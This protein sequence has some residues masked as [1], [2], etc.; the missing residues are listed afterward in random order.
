MTGAGRAVGVPRT[1]EEITAGWLAEV[2]GTDVGTITVEPVGL[3]IGLMG[4]LYR[5]RSD[6]DGVPPV[7]V[8]LATTEPGSRQVAEAF[9]FYEKEARFYTELA[10]EVPVATPRVFAA[11]WDPAT[12][13]VVLVLEDLSDAR[14]IDQLTGA[15]AEEAATLVSALGDLHAA[16]WESPR[17]GT[18]G[19]LPRL[20]D[21][22]FPQGLAQSTAQAGP[23]FAELFGARLPRRLTDLPERMPAAVGPL[24][25]QLSEAPVT[26]NHGDWR[27]DNFFFRGGSPVVI[28]W[29]ICM[30]ASGAYD[31]G[32]FMSQSLDPEV[33]RA[34]GEDLVDLYM[35]RLTAAGVR[36]DPTGLRTQHRRAVL[37]TFVY[38]LV[39]GGQA[40]LVNDRATELVEIMVDRCVSAIVDL[41][42]DELM[43]RP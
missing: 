29:Q 26:L 4:L 9:R 3:G 34:H 2:L 1:V 24:M 10:S 36:F 18:L 35:E 40:E 23:R 39:S 20:C 6:V 8:K 27:L 37:L 22:P 28:D 42:A 12:G 5:V 19:W 7:I 32:Y 43:P 17:F 41:D 13:D 16:W 30:K 11:R 31:L 15:T 14:A 21:P 25:E 33:R 38:P